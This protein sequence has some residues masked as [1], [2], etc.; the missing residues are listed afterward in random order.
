MKMFNK[1]LAI[2]LTIFTLVSALPMSVFADAWLD[3][4]ASTNGSSSKVQL[5]LDAGAIADILEKDGISPA[6]L[7]DLMAGVS[8]DVDALKE[9]FTVSELLEIIPR[10]SWLEIFDVDEIVEAIGVDT[11]RSYVNLAVLAKAADT[12]KL[13]ALM[14]ELGAEDLDKIL[15]VAALVEGNYINADTVATYVNEDALFGAEGLLTPQEI[16]DMMMDMPLDDLK[17]CFHWANYNKLMVEAGMV[18]PALLPPTPLDGFYCTNAAFWNDDETRENLVALLETV[19]MATLQKY[20]NQKNMDLIMATAPMPEATIKALYYDET[21]GAWSVEKVVAVAMAGGASKADALESLL[22]PSFIDVPAMTV[23][24]EIKASSFVSFA[25]SVGGISAMVGADTKDYIVVNGTSVGHLAAEVGGYGAL[26]NCVDLQGLFKEVKVADVIAA[27][28]ADEDA[29]LEDVVDFDVLIDVVGV[30]DLIDVVGEGNVFAELDNKELFEILQRI[31]VKQYVLPVLTTVFDK[32]MRNVDKLTVNGFVVAEEDYTKTL[33]F[34]SANLVKAFASL[35]PTLDE[36]AS[37]ED[38]KLVSMNVE[39]VYTVDGTIDQKKTKNVTFE[40]VVEG[41]LSRLQNAA[42]KLDTLL[43][44]YINKFDISGGVLTLDVTAPSVLTKLYARV[45]D[46]D[47]LPAALKEKL[48]AIPTLSGDDAVAMMESLTFEEIVALLDA[49]EPTK[50]YNAL[51]NISYVQVAVDKV[52]DKLGYNLADVTLDDMLNAAANVPSVERICEVIENKVGVDVMKYIETLAIK[53]DDLVD[54]AEKISAVQKILDKVG[55]KLNVDLSAISAAE[56]VDRAKD[57]PISE[58]VSN[59]IASKIGVDVKA[60][61]ETYT[62]DELYQIAVDKAAEKEGV[63]NKVKNYVLA[64]ADKLPDELMSICIGNAYDK[65]GVF[66]VDEKVTFNAKALVEKVINKVAEKVDAVSGVKAL[67]D[68]IN[69]GT[70]TLGANLTVRF[71][72]LYEVT[73][74]SRDGLTP[75]FKAYLPVGADLDVFKNNPGVT[76]YEFVAWTDADGNEVTKMPAE[77]FTVYADRNMVQVTFKDEADNTV[78]VIMMEQGDTLGKYADQLAAIAG[79]IDLSNTAPVNPLLFDEYT[80][81]WYE[82][83]ESGV[84]GRVFASTKIDADLT[85]VGTPVPD[86]FLRFD[87]EVDYDVTENNGAYVITVKGDMPEAFVLDLDYAHL[88][89]RANSS[90]KVSLK[91]SSAKDGYDF[92][93]F[94]DATLA[95]LHGNARNSVFFSYETAD[96]APKSFAGTAYAKAKGVDFYS[97]ELLVDG[98]EFT[99]G[100]KAPIRIQVPYANATANSLYQAVRVR[101]MKNGVREAVDC[102]VV[103]VGGENYVWFDAMHFSDFAVA[104]EARLNLEITDGTNPVD[105]YMKNAASEDGYYPIGERITLAFVVP[106]YKIVSIVSQIP[107]KAEVE[108]NNGESVIMTENGLDVTVT[109]ELTDFYIYYYVNGELQNDLTQN[110]TMSQVNAFLADTNNKP[111]DFLADF[112]TAV[113][114][115]T[116]VPAGY[117]KAGEWGGFTGEFGIANMYLYADWEATKYT[118]EFVGAKTFTDVT[119]ENYATL[120]TEPAVPAQE[121]KMGVWEAYDLSKLATNAVNGTYKINAKYDTVLSYN[122]SLGN[123][124]TVDA[125][126]GKAA[127]GTTVTVTVDT[128]NYNPAFYD[129]KIVVTKDADGSEVPVENGAFTMP[130]GN[131]HVSVEF[132]PKEISYKING[133]EYTGVYGETASY[134]VT[135]KIGEVL[136]SVPASWV[137]ASY[138]SDASA[139]KTIVYEFVVAEADASYTVEIDDAMIA[140]FKIVNG[141][142]FS[143]EG[144]PEATQKNVTFKEWSETVANSLSFAMF[145]ITRTQSF[146]WLWIL[147]AILLLIL[148]IA[149]LYYLY[150]TGKIKRPLFLLRFVTWVVGLFFALCLAISG[151]GLKIAKLFGK[152][153]DPD[154]YG[155][156]KEEQPE[157]APVADAEAEAE[158]TA[159]AETEVTAEDVALAAAAAEAAETAETAEVA[160]EAP[161][162]AAEEAPVE[163]AEEAPV[164]AAEEAPVEAAEEAPAE[165]AEE[166]PV[167]AAEEAPAEAAEEAPAEAAE[168]APVEAAEEAPVE[169]AEE[170]PAEA[171]E[172]APAEAAEEVPAEAAEEVPAEATEEV[173]TEATEEAEKAPSKEEKKEN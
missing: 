109:V 148:I 12:E 154:D 139:T 124:V 155:F 32:V 114:D 107:G 118:V 145:T 137:V 69:G 161:A 58:T 135:V 163:A 152:S 57:A 106:G 8:V 47:K 6:L 160:E 68:R 66:N 111:V 97:F 168:E 26:I 53:A 11:L 25:V 5:T 115:V 142:L 133:T 108:R 30:T 136:T 82:K 102:D 172:E 84:A 125:T 54:R 10:G 9:A 166:A 39:M 151:L 70:I 60:V 2:V 17:D 103:T 75:L 157:T 89:K 104:T 117:E 101:T 79:E 144:N 159:E 4:D 138:T 71:Q 123:N 173:P 121:G 50:L 170:A 16:E 35:I 65:N 92:V 46:A 33:A 83:T 19:D 18:P 20:S 90:A 28:D 131:V 42:A 91:I 146:L 165:A 74:M 15:D 143:G 40:F 134:T 44:T 96:G 49:V 153:D 21:L 77:D 164:E 1:V 94:E 141:K 87:G 52:G 37:I 14:A 27:V 171:A 38:G 81:A 99:K 43:K 126:N 64:I 63:Y 61:L 31:D 80:V 59:A 112:A 85:V 72:N 24:G 22:S 7:K 86:Y 122:V 98:N 116:N 100:F 76:G 130:A 34:N 128:T 120:V 78:G 110:Y 149:V 88:L 73:Y 93:T 29:S 113:K 45:L 3:V 119:V 140:L 56:I 13:G 156:E 167:E 67:L 169:A 132:E 23:D 55:A 127:Y 147:L 51:L 41:D 162:E 158:A 62:A 48:V 150:I 105:G 36:F 129:A 95:Q